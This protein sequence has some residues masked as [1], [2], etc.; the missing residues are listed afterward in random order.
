MISNALDLL[1]VVDLSKSYSNKAILHDISFNVQSGDCLCI[2]GGSGIGKSLLLKLLTGLEVPDSGRVMY[3]GMDYGKA[4]EIQWNK[5]R[6]D[7]GVVF[8]SA[9]LL[10]S[11]TI[12]ENLCLRLSYHK[13]YELSDIQRYAE[14]V[15]SRVGLPIN[16]SNLKPAE[17][18]GGMRKRVGIARALMHKPNWMFYDEPTSGLDPIN[19][20]LIDKL[21]YTLYRSGKTSI[22]ITHDLESVRRYATSVLWLQGGSE[23]GY[24]SADEFWKSGSELLSRGGFHLS[25]NS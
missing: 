10:D 25:G 15:L 9:A 2:V 21:I 6:E 20:D 11:L 17:L 24:G 19:A 16:I 18:S 8:Q 3:N 23:Y 13:P 1:E 7:M 14:F 12:Q 22:V 5:I 4:N